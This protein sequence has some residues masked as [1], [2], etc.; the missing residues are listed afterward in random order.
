MQGGFG[1]VDGFGVVVRKAGTQAARD[2]AADRAGTWTGT[3]LRGNPAVLA[4]VTVVRE[5]PLRC[6]AG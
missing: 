2:A 4:A 5:L 3:S 1:L 6:A